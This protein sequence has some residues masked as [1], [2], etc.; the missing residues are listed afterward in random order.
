MD[1]AN[2]RGAVALRWER[3]SFCGATPGT[4][5]ALQGFQERGIT[6]N[7]LCYQI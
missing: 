4:G 2:F 5:Q 6:R 7:N 1:T 3:P